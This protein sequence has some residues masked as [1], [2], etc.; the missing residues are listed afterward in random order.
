M[1]HLWS[2]RTFRR[3]FPSSFDQLCP[4]L[5]NGRTLRLGAYIAAPSVVVPGDGRKPYGYLVRAFQLLG[6]RYGFRPE[7]FFSEGYFVHRNRTW[8]GIY[9]NVRAPLLYVQQGT[10]LTTYTST[11]IMAFASSSWTV[12]PRW[13]RAASS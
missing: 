11:T 8:V 4:D 13:P 1:R 5:L 7:I 2:V 10:T 6:E 12:H 3:H 9:K